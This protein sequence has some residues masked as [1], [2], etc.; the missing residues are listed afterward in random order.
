MNHNKTSHS[1]C[2]Y[3]GSHS[4]CV[5]DDDGKDPFVSNISFRK[6]K[7]KSL[8]R[9][10]NS[11]CIFLTMYYI[12]FMGSSGTLHQ[13]SYKDKNYIAHTILVVEI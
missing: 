10:V 7:I 12:H 13:Q 8:I 9:Q 5:G 4:V 3:R 11:Y 1:V 2:K 6:T